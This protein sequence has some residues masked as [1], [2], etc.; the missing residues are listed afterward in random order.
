MAVLISIA[1]YSCDKIDNPFISNSGNVKIPTSGLTRV[2]STTAASDNLIRVL[3][4]DYTG[5]LCTNCPAAAIQC[6]ALVSAHPTQIVM[7]QNNATT[8]A[9]AASKGAYLAQGLPDTAYGNNYIASAD[10]EW[11]LT[12]IN[13]DI[14]GM[15]EVMVDR[16]YFN[17]SPGS[18]NVFSSGMAAPF[19]SLISTPPTAKIHI[20]DSLYAPPVST[21]SMSITTTLLSPVAGTKYFL[22]VGL[23]EDSIYDWQDS[24]QHNVQYYLKRMTFR[25]A[26]NDGGFGFGDSL[27]ANSLPQAKHYA[28]ANT[29]SFAYNSA[30]VSKPPQVA[31]RY[32]NM[33][34]MYA[35]AFVYQVVSGKNN[36]MV[37]Q[38]QSLHL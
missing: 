22:V 25:T 31:A 38:A 23:V 36:Y 13:G 29:K 5:H 30:V 24:V 11:N 18:P 15:P 37:L 3:V 34:H 35:V 27:V 32:W 7:I 14:N 21:V 16:L 19:D 20:V 8:L 1:I 2:D 10:S 6:E 4:E 33:A 9:K 17:G 28:Y 26:I 12:F